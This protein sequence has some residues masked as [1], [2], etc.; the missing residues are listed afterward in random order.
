MI[1]ASASLTSAVKV[2]RGGMSSYLKYRDFVERV[3]DR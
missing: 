2:G 1:P 3:S